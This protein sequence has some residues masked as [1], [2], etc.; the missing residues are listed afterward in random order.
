MELY[1][2]QRNYKNIQLLLFLPRKVLPHKCCHPSNKVIGFMSV[3]RSVP[4]T[5]QK[6]SALLRI[7]FLFK[8]KINKKKLCQIQSPPPLK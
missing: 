8:S 3:C 4:P 6:E 7:F 5:S 2:V 1:L